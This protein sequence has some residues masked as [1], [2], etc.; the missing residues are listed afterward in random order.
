MN[1]Y[2]TRSWRWSWLSPAPHS[3]TRCRRPWCPDEPGHS[4]RVNTVIVIVV[5]STEPSRSGL[6]SSLQWGTLGICPYLNINEINDLHKS[7]CP[8][9]N[10]DMTVLRTQARV[11]RPNTTSV[12][13]PC[14]LTTRDTDSWYPAWWLP[15][16]DNCAAPSW[17]SRRRCSWWRLAPG[18]APW[19]SPAAR[20]RPA[21]APWR[22]GARPTRAATGTPRARPPGQMYQYHASHVSSVSV[23]PLW[24]AARAGGGPGRRPGAWSHAPAAAGRAAWWA[25]GSSSAAGPHT[26]LQRA[27]QT[28]QAVAAASWFTAISIQNIYNVSYRDDETSLCAMMIHLLTIYISKRK[29]KSCFQ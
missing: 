6:R 15:T 17:R 29:I 14:S 12:S 7:T 10:A 21:P 23:W 16:V 3:C 9:L 2:I 4:R 28:V 25:A 26:T 20:A 8:W 19:R 22:G 27:L 24:R 18:P 1:I 13:I 11:I 5:L